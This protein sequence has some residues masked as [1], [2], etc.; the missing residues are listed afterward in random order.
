MDARA[1]APDL[2]R[3]GHDPDQFVT[4]QLPGTGRHQRGL[5][6]LIHGGYWRAK[7][8]ATV[9]LPMA[10]VLLQQG[11]A[12]VNIEYRRGP[13]SQWPVPSRD[14]SK[15]VGLAQKLRA[16][17]KIAG[18]MILIGHSVG[19]QLALLNAQEVDGV[20]ALSPVTDV[21][22]TYEEGLGDRAAQ[23]Y[24][25]VSPRERPELYRSASPL[26]QPSPNAAVLIVHGANDDRVPVEHSRAYAKVLAQNGAMVQFTEYPRL[27]H[28]QIIAPDSLHWPETFSWMASVP[29]GNPLAPST[30]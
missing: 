25:Q 23:E 15:A 14:V 13:A 12:V 27:G 10:E 1:D 18:P 19:G 6:V 24:F 9:M 11:W 29:A 5:A 28:M 8:D 2:R 30:E 22:R 17:S 26:R 16:S 3:Y 7:V 21:E 20:V 4:M